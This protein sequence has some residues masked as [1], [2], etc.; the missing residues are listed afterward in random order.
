MHKI[1]NLSVYIFCDDI[2]KNYSRK[3]KLGIY[4][5]VSPVTEL[6]LSTLSQN[7][8]AWASNSSQSF[9]SSP[10]ASLLFLCLCLSL[11]SFMPSLSV[12]IT[13]LQY[14]SYRKLLPTKIA[15][16]WSYRLNIKDCNNY[17]PKNLASTIYFDCLIFERRE[18]FIPWDCLT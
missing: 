1:I 6:R 13:D 8:E 4:Q 10:H 17:L 7:T 5:D 3:Y 2:T 18:L 9:S 16:L 15:S 11:E 12:Y 14:S